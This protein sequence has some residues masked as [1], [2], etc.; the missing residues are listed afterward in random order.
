MKLS[1]TTGIFVGVVLGGLGAFCPQLKASDR[2]TPK[3]A[4]RGGN[5]VTATT[6]T[7]FDSIFSCVIVH[8]NKLGSRG[9]IDANETIEKLKERKFPE[10]SVALPVTKDLNL[11]GQPSSSGQITVSQQLFNFVEHSLSHSYSKKSEFERTVWFEDLFNKSLDFL[12]NYKSLFALEVEKNE[13]EASMIRKKKEIELMNAATQMKISDPT[14]LFFAQSQ[15]AKLEQEIISLNQRRQS[16]L[17]QISLTA[18]VSAIQLIVE[19]SSFKPEKGN[20]ESE[21]FV[22]KTD[23]KSDN[24]KFVE[25]HPGIHKYQIKL[26]ELKKQRESV[27]RYWW[28]KASL[29]GTY[30]KNLDDGGVP[31][32]MVATLQLSANLM[33]SGVKDAERNALSK[34]ILYLE[35]LQNRMLTKVKEDFADLKKEISALMEQKSKLE[36]QKQKAEMAY[37]LGLKKFKLDRL[38]YFNLSSL[39]ENLQRSLFA[40]K[41]VEVDIWKANL[42][43]EIYTNFSQ[44]DFLKKLL[45]LSCN[46][47]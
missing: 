26:E 45:N 14:D 32:T 24:L 27:E 46:L 30:T 31:S 21:L 23:L 16:I 37:D 47:K 11:G 2:V 25:D 17:T 28:P 13:I 40:L 29:S 8:E 44:S 5:S 10:L 34:Q 35:E 39:E 9:L 12:N 3:E 38:T 33:E 18:G 22:K 6:S 42:A 15:L 7:R 41:K 20:L 36:I 43:L 4:I 1:E 19:D